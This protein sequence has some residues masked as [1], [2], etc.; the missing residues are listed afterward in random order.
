[1][2]QLR[3]GCRRVR[4]VRERTKGE[5]LLRTPCERCGHLPQW[6]GVVPRGVL[7]VMRKEPSATVADQLA[8]VE[9]MTATS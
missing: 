9:F 4:I 2:F 7:R 8:F 1:M 3:C 5:R 6:L